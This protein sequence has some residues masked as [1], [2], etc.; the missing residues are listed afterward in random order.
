M[1]LSH[2][3]PNFTFGEEMANTITHAMGAGYSLAALGIFAVDGVK[4]K[5]KRKLFGNVVFGIGLLI[6][7][8]NSA[9]FHGLEKGELKSKWRYV[10]HISIFVLIAASY[11][12]ICLVVLRFSKGEYL[13]GAVWLLGIIGIAMKVLF[14]EQFLLLSMGVYLLMG[15]MFVFVLKEMLK[16]ARKEFLF[17]LL[18]GG[19]SYSVAV[20]FYANDHKVRYFHM[21]FHI[22]ILIGSISHSIGMLFY[23]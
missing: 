21:I 10:D 5:N 23:I 17:W 2:M 19:I 3:E 4:S 7:Y 1:V 22:L 8:M 18:F 9:I 6:L 16:N 13:L 20:Y 14:F 11:T 15:W 12:P